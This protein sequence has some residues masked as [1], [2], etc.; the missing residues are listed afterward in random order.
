MK[1]LELVC[2]NLVT[3]PDKRNHASRV[4]QI[5]G[6]DNDVKFYD[7][8]PNSNGGRY[9]C[10]H[11]HMSVIAKAYEKGIEHLIVFEDDVFPTTLYSKS[12]F[13]WCVEWMQTNKDTDMFF[14]G[15]FPV[16]GPK[17][18]ICPYLIAKHISGFP[19]LIHFLPVGFHAYCISRK[20]MEK[21]LKSHWKDAIKNEHFDVFVAKMKS[22]NSVC[23]VP[24]LFGQYSCFGSD[25]KPQDS[26]EV[27]MRN[28]HCMSDLFHWFF[29]VSLLKYKLNVMMEYF[30]VF[31][32]ISF[33]AIVF[34][35]I[36]LNSNLW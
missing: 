23:Y 22:I 25:N 18:S 4:F 6:L 16:K 19:N 31:V 24:C 30:W 36:V 14:F 29:K 26:L 28:F 9:G 7:A 5:C 34:T 3:R 2:I 33:I 32:G 20:G 27:F 21:I 11:S 17:E 8:L 35:L 10:F 13:M 15:S 12:Q 1:N